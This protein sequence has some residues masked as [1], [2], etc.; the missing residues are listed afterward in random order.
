MHDG[1]RGLLLAGRAYD[2]PGWGDFGARRCRPD[3]VDLRDEFIDDGGSAAV[4]R[5][6]QWQPEVS[7]RAAGFGGE[8]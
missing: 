6:A 7:A 8:P 1:E 3:G 5:D 4:G 2:G